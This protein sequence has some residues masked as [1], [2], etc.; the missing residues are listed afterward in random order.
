V[1]DGL[2]HLMTTIVLR[3]EMAMPF[4]SVGYDQR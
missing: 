1:R 3:H 2:P 4:I